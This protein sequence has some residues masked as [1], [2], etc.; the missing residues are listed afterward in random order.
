[1]LCTSINDLINAISENFKW[2]SLII[3]PIL[4]AIFIGWKDHRM[5]ESEKRQSKSRLAKALF[6]EISTLMSIYDK[7]ISGS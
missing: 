2:L 3:S 4:T 6:A 7:M 1:M 5:K